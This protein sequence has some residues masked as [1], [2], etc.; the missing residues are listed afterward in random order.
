MNTPFPTGIT[1]TEEERLEC[2]GLTIQ[3]QNTPVI[4]VDG[5]T[6][7]SQM[8]WQ[9]ARRAVHRYALAH[10]LP[11]IPGYYGANLETGEFLKP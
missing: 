6:S 2:R 3:A 4:S 5:V 9:T 1:M 7:W 10:G 11:E 8:A